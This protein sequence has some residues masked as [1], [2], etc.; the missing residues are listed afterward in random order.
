MN[1][2]KKTQKTRRI[3]LYYYIITGSI[4]TTINYIIRK[5]HSHLSAFYQCFPE[6][7]IHFVY[8]LLNV[9]NIK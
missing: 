7:L 4:N 5:K 2:L 6:L 8:S 9:G 3:K 1:L